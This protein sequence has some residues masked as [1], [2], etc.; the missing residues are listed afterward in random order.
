[1]FPYKILTN[2]ITILMAYDMAKPLTKTSE[3]APLKAAVA[4]IAETSVNP[5]KYS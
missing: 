3:K 4:S 1:M 5:I 2:L